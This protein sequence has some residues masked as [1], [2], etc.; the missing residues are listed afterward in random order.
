[1]D[2][3]ILAS[4]LLT[5]VA[6]SAAVGSAQIKG[7]AEGSLI[8]GSASFEDT[9][10]GL[11]IDLSVAGLTPGQH[12]FHIHEWGDCSDTGKAA[13]GH[14]NPAH[15]MHGQALKSGPHKAHAGDAGNLVADQD[16]RA[17]LEVVLPGVKL[18]QGEFTVAGRAVIIHEKAD[19]FSQPVGNAG[20]RVACGLI[21]LVP[22]QTA[23][24]K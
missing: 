5:A 20:G 11:K 18:T 7:T 21:G 12:G 4:L 10:K 22:G 14:Y 2:K 19:D 1:M 3:L 23:A 8:S 13:G 16:G 15:A 6:A 24:P 17:K 9:A